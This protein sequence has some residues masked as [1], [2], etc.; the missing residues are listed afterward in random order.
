[1]PEAFSQHPDWRRI[2]TPWELTR[3]AGRESP[4]SDW[5]RAAVPGAVQLDWA[6]AHGLPDLNFG[7]NVRLY[8]GLEDSA[9]LY[10]T[11]VP[12]AEL[13]PAE[14]LVFACGGVDYACEVRLAGRPVLRHEGLF[15]PFEVALAGCPTGA[16]LEVLVLPAP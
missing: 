5:I 2:A 6:R 16:P 7:Q 10:R 1:M 3:L 9:W 15:T 14:E 12:Q 13:A 11:R 8:D 4:A